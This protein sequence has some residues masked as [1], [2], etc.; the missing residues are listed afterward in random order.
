MAIGTFEASGIIR[1]RDPPAGFRPSFVN[2]MNRYGT[3]E[4]GKYHFNTS[5]RFTPQMWWF[6]FDT[7]QLKMHLQVGKTGGGLVL[8]QVDVQHPDR[9]QEWEYR[10]GSVEIEE[11]D[12]GKY[13]V[14]IC[15][16]AKRKGWAL[17]KTIACP[18]LI[19]ALMAIVSCLGQTKLERVSTNETCLGLLFAALA[20]QFTITDQVPRTVTISWIDCGFSCLHLLIVTSWLK[21]ALV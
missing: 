11:L 13:S 8:G 6:P 12:A 21:N 1:M 9:S 20:L 2:A 4:D 5:F 19:I 17:V 3:G 16:E 14:M 7:H 18:F 10:L 15:F